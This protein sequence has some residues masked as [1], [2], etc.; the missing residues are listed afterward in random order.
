MEGVCEYNGGRGRRTPGHSAGDDDMGNRLAREPRSR[1]GCGGGCRASAAPPSRGAD[2]LHVGR[3]VGH[4]RPRHDSGVARAAEPAHWR[5]GGCRVLL[6]VLRRLHVVG[7]AEGPAGCDLVRAHDAARA[8]RYARRAAPAA[9][10]RCVQAES[11]AAGRA[12]E[13]RA[14]HDASVPSR[15]GVARNH[16][17]RGSA[18]RSADRQPARAADCGQRRRQRV[19]PRC[20]GH[21]HRAVAVGVRGFPCRAGAERGEA[22]AARLERADAVRQDEPARPSTA[23]ASA[24]VCQ[25]GEARRLL[26]AGESRQAG[27]RRRRHAPDRLCRR[28]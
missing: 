5:V 28:E 18:T 6:G 16:R 19:P 11:R 14:Q 4:A 13:G 22:A 26:H 21:S 9:R 10:R 8:G 3:Y 24:G 27:R 12:G 2:A 1:A 7:D 23:P 20:G 15:R 25:C 17:R